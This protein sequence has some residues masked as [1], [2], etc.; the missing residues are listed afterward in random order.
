MMVFGWENITVESIKPIC[1]QYIGN[2]WVKVFQKWKQY[3][4]HFIAI[5]TPT[6]IP[7]EMVSD[8]YTNKAVVG[9]QN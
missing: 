2:E 1:S 4:D 9:T 8:S 6:P 3:G 5:L 7:L